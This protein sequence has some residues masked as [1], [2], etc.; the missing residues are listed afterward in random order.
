MFDWV[1]YRSPLYRGL[2]RSK[3]SQ[4]LQRVASLVDFEKKKKSSEAAKLV[5]Q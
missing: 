3:S 2:R 5:F 4:L 1:M